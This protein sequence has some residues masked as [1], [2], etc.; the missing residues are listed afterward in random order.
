M[1]KR[2][3]IDLETTG[4]Y[5]WKHGIHQI[6]GIVD[7]DGKIVEEFDIR[8][9]PNERAIIDDDA[10]EISGITKADILKYPSQLDGFLALSKILN[11]YVNKFDKTDKF[12]ICGFNNS[13]FDNDF[14]RAFFVQCEDKFFG[15]WFWPNPIDVYILA[16][17]HFIDRRLEFSDFKLKTVAKYIG[18]DVDDTKLHDGIYDIKLTRDIY[19]FLKNNKKS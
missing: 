16:S 5:Y 14:L 4:P 13:K 17:E 1:I 11:K 8:V 7:I 15:S 2:I 6:A 3:F 10:L 19:Y 18:L 12:F 9:R